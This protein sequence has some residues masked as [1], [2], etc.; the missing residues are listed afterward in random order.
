MPFTAQLSYD[1]LV[2]LSNGSTLKLRSGLRYRSAYDT[3][4]LS[5]EAA[6]LGYQPWV[7]TDEQYLGDLSA[8]WS[9]SNDN[10]SLTAYVR[11]IG[12]NE[13]RTNATLNLI[14]QPMGP[15]IV[16]ADTRLTE[17]LTFGFVLTARR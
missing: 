2:D 1:R 14:A 12:D 17:P 16:S 13:H 11:N 3:N 10:L 8:T 7:R 4:P 5:S 9:S 15:A 6:A